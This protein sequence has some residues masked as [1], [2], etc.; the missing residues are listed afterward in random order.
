[1]HAMSSGRSLVV[2]RRRL[3]HDAVA[4]RHLSLDGF[5]Q[6]QTVVLHHYLDPG[7]TRAGLSVIDRP[8]HSLPEGFRKLG[9]EMP[10]SRA[11]LEAAMMAMPEEERQRRLAE[12]F[13]G[14]PRVFIGRAHDESAALV[15]SDGEGRPRIML[16]V[17]HEGEPYIRILHE[18]GTTVMSWP[19]ES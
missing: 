2:S 18:D 3:R 14:A 4:I 19:K 5:K 10:A 1:M 6:D 11:D 13:G 12:A 17:P 15:L 8:Q 7:G 16:G 9:I